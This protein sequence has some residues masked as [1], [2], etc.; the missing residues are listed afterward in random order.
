MK[1]CMLGMAALL[2]A[3]GLAQAQA[4]AATRAEVTQLL[5]RVE[6]SQCKFNRNGS[7][8]DAKSARKHLQDKFDYLDKK[9]M[10]ATTESFIDK[11]ASRSSTSGKAYQI[12]CPGGQAMPSAAWMTAE[13]NR[14]RL[15]R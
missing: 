10:V 2:C 5:D 1:L 6:S 15:S 8:H 11:G 13:L 7:W 3:A 14:L 9:N 4:P 12:F